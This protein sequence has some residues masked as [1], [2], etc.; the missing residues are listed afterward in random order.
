MGSAAAL[1]AANVPEPTSVGLVLCGVALYLAA[2]LATRVRSVIV[3]IGV[4]CF[5]AQP[6]SM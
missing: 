3:C 2:S 4:A 6:V 5:R 1:S